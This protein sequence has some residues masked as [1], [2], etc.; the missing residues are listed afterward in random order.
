MHQ[1]LQEMEA[2]AQKRSRSRLGRLRK[3][4]QQQEENS[5]G[6]FPN[7]KDGGILGKR[8]QRSKKWVEQQKIEM[9]KSSRLTQVEAKIDKGVR[10]ADRDLLETNGISAA[11]FSRVRAHRSSEGLEDDRFGG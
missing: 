2:S 7:H 3:K 4:K 6:V 9:A 10:T 11:Q 1:R 8:K 5:G